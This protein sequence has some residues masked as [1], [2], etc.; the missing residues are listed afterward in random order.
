MLFPLLFYSVDWLSRKISFF[1]TVFNERPGVRRRFT[2][3]G[4]GKCGSDPLSLAAIVGATL[5]INSRYLMLSA[6]FAVK[7]EHF[8]LPMRFFALYTLADENWAVAM[9]ESRRNRLSVAYLLGVSLPFYL[10]WLFWTQMGAWFGQLIQDPEKF[11]LDFVYTAVFVSLLAG[12][13]KS[14]STYL[15]M[16]VGGGSAMLVWYLADGIWYIVVGGFTWQ[17]DRVDQHRTGG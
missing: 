6:A 16:A 13:A 11:G 8:S 3:A 10:N 15:P 14:R 7:I 1:R 12:F 2:N 4:A 9:S 17:L 5:M